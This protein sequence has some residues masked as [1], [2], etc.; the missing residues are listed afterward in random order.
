[1]QGHVRDD[2]RRLDCLQ[3]S[4]ADAGDGAGSSLNDVRAS[5]E[6]W[7]AAAIA[8]ESSQLAALG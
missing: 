8:R 4:R 3:F 5:A 2:G 6:L 1:M 7:S